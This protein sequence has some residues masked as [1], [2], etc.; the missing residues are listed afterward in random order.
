VTVVVL[1]G[2][3]GL[4]SLALGSAAEVDRVLTTNWIPEGTAAPVFQALEK[5]YFKQEGINLKIVRGYGSNKTAGDVDAGK[6]DF[7][8]G[9]ITAVVLVRAKGGTTKVLGLFMDKSPVGLGT[10]APLPLKTPKDLEGQAIGISAFSITRN[11]LP[12]LAAKNGVDYSKIRIITVQPGVGH[13]QFLA[14]K[15]P[16]SDMWEASSKEIAIVKGKQAGKKINYMPFRNFGL[17]IYSM[18]FWVKEANLKKDPKVIRSFLKA[19][20][21]GFADT[22]KDRKTAF[23]SLMKHHPALDK[24]I[25]TMQVDTLVDSM[26]DWKR[27]DKMG[28][29]TVEE[30]KMKLTLDTVRKGFK[31]KAKLKAKDL[32]TNDFLPKKM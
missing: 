27:W 6:T 25:T 28:P 23:N 7:G 1:A 16:V 14:G 3:L 30:A 8:Y 11:L 18:T 24:A 5:G 10:L 4:F 31:V 15:F 26:I 19:A 13:S 17:D 29:G 21:R 2:G 20:Y 22:R 9:D 32:Y 12:I